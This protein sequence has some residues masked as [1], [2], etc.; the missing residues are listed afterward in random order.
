[1]SSTGSLT[2]DIRE[3]EVALAA[4]AGHGGGMSG[5]YYA[6]GPKLN[7]GRFVVRPHEFHQVNARHS[8]AI[9]D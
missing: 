9:Q 5:T 3:G 7:R 2:A 8:G 4:G 1:M 6:H